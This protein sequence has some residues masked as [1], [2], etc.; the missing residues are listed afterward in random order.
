MAD[1][2]TDKKPRDRWYWFSI[3]CFDDGEITFC[4]IP[5]WPTFV[6]Y[7]HGGREECPKTKKIHF[8]GAV[9]CKT[10]Q[11]FSAIKKMLPKA[12]IEP[13]RTEQALLKYAMKK[14][15]AVGEKKSL[16]NEMP[17]YTTEMLLRLLAITSPIG[18]DDF[19]GRVNRILFAKPYLCGVLAKPD[20][21]RMWK[22]TRET[23]ITLMTD[24]ETNLLMGEE[25][26]VLQPPTGSGE[27]ISHVPVDNGSDLQ[28]A[29][30]ETES[31]R[32][33]EEEC[34]ALGTQAQGWEYPTRP[35]TP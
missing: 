16:K 22:H 8:Q 27:F 13:A 28:E 11:R 17:Y 19:W 35:R 2:Q 9:Q 14:D 29:C 34:P 33:E 30:S 12:H 21:F 3:T 32:F 6:K 25:A 15:T 26:I 1:R 24:P 10:Q 23:W 7:I 18:S 20:I 31:F 5:L 4:E